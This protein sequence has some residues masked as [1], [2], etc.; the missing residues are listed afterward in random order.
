MPYAPPAQP[1]YG[2]ITP[3]SLFNH[4]ETGGPGIVIDVR[5]F[6]EFEKERIPGSYNL[7]LSSLEPEDVT[8]LL[9]KLQKPFTDPLYIT[10][11]VGPRALQAC[12]L[13]APHFPHVYHV[14]T[15]LKG[16]I[17]QGYP[18]EQGSPSHV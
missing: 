17:G 4:L 1:S 6:Q 10:C 18:V 14:V 8:D 5:S 9:K 11:A 15:C 12:D 2:H 7:P 16:W 13:L 3:E